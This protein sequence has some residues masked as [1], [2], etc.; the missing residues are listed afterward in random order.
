MGTS[1]SK[2]SIWGSWTGYI[3]RSSVSMV[4]E[5]SDTGII[6]S[7]ESSRGAVWGKVN[8]SRK[9]GEAAA[10]M[11]RWTRNSVGLCCSP[12]TRMMSAS[13][14]SKESRPMVRSQGNESGQCR[15]V[16]IYSIESHVS[17]EG[18]GRI[19]ESTILARQTAVT[20]DSTR[21]KIDSV[22]SP[23]K[24]ALIGY[25]TSSSATK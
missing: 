10:R 7:C 17:S 16:T 9:N 1:C 18:S 21:N 24:T 22:R 8:M 3:K 12:E 19:P 13:V 15:M 11:Q 4:Q 2:E 20:D 14:A 5:G 23:P 6:G 25:L